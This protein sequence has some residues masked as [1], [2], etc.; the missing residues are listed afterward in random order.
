MLMLRELLTVAPGTT[1]LVIQDNHKPVFTNCSTYQPT[2]KE[3]QD[4]GT[5]VFTVTAVDKDPPESGGTVTYTFVEKRDEKTPKFN[6]DP[7]T[8]RFDRDEPIREK[9]EYLVV[10]ATDNG[11]P[12][13]DDVCNIKVVIEDINDNS[14]VFDKVTY[15]ESVP[16]DLAVGREVM[17]IS[18]TDIDDGNN[19]RVAYSLER[20]PGY[21]RIDSNNGVIFLDKP[22]DMDPG[23]K[24][25]MTGRA[26]DS[27][28]PPR[29][30]E[31]ELEV[32]VVESHK[33]AP[34]FVDGGATW[35]ITLPENYSNY[36]AALPNGVFK[37]VSNVPED[38]EVIFTLVSGATE[39]TNKLGTFILETKGDTAFIKLGSALDYET[40]NEYTL[41]LGVRNK[42]KL[43]A[44]T[45]I[46]VFVTDVNDHIPSFNFKEVPEGIVLE[47]EPPGTPVMQVRAIDIDGTSANNIVSYKLDENSKH[48]DLF[49]IDK[50]TGNI[51]T[52]REFDREENNRYQI[53]VIAYDNSPSALKN[54]GEP[55]TAE[56]SF[57][58]NIGDK[59][60]N[61]PVFTQKIY[62]AEEIPENANT[63]AL[64]TEV[65]AL[66]KDTASPVTYDILEGNVG[67]AFYIENTTGK[68]RV[69]NQLDY[70]SITAYT[71]TVRA[72]DGKYNDTAK[73]EIKIANVNDNPPVFLKF[74]NN[75][76]IQEEMIVEGCIANLEA[77]DPDIQDRSAPQHI[78]FDVVKEDQKALLSIDE[79]GCLRLIKPLDRDPP[80]GSPV[81]QVLIA[82]NDEDGGPS[83]LQSTAEL[84]IILEDIN[85]NAP[86]LDMVQPVVWR[87]NQPPGKITTLKAKDYDSEAN[88]APFKFR[89]D[90]SAGPEITNNFAIRNGDENDNPMKPGQSNI[91]VYNYKGEAP[92]TEVGRVYVEDPDDWDLPDKY[93]VWKNGN[94]PNFD[95]NSNTGMITMLSHIPDGTYILE[96]TVTEEAPLIPRHSVDAIVN[97]TIKVIPEEAVDKSGSIRF[98]GITAPEFV[99][100]GPNGSPSK[101]ELLRWR[102]ASLL[103]VSVENVDVFTVLHSPHNTN[104]TQLDVRY[105]AH[106]SPYRQP[107]KL[108]NLLAAHQEE[109]EQE[110]GLT[111]LMVNI[112]EC[113]M[114]KVFC[115]TESCTNFLNKSNVP[116]AVY[117]NTSS[118]VGVRAVVDPLC[119]CKVK[120]RPICLNGGTPIGPFNCECIDGF[121]GPYC[122]LISIGFHGK[123]WALY[124]PLSACEEARVSLEVTPYTEDG[125]ILYVGPLRYNPA[126]HVQDFMSLELRSGFPRLLMD[127]GTGT[128]FVENKQIKLSDNK[129]HHIDVIWS[130]TS[131]ELKVDN[132]QMSSCLALT[133]PQGPNEFLNVNGPVQLG[134]TTIDLLSL[135]KL[136]NWTHVP[137][138]EGFS[139]CIRNLTFNEKINNNSDTNNLDI[140][141]QLRIRLCI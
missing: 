17:R 21:F 28:S 131:I 81:W 38:S 123:G 67:D 3:E 82:A 105:S 104:G 89:I 128:V 97:I 111:I 37:A 132:C 59:N 58:I 48:R 31:I 133:T 88:G 116:Y 50:D 57:W 83:S 13:L 8:G 86:I 51:T 135:S 120:E 64:V 40:I 92:D 79:Q 107:E 7:N 74:N 87:E 5:Y 45:S 75:I 63:N 127:Y 6:I 94:H 124:P 26:E 24:F 138:S 103:N 66:D 93:F 35:D 95:L 9:E 78:Q 11:R 47:N 14:P 27:G 134:G 108:N 19:S 101:Q 140:E 125:L 61:P 12:Q 53:K 46:N 69:K 22:I 49:Q 1:R 90:D 71:L 117:T 77:Y 43:A 91:F 25:T 130:K 18:A 113:L 15:L 85:D 33:K 56:L 20:N 70:E 2:V 126:L 34:T 73:V 44:E 100:P 109:I 42:H 16:Q 112:D 99:A 115:E 10:R 118:F 129:P 121:E 84:I 141:K 119:N 23:H 36:T 52:L 139:G 122:E 114:E 55:N 30:T 98:A 110:L 136:M 137:T 65:K 96:F 54:N 80:N 29:M 68:I 62:V 106:G 76:T 4:P 32:L 41:T 39:Q 102:L 72:F 60:D